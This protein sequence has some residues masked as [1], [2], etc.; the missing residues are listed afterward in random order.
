MLFAGW[1]EISAPIAL[2]FILLFVGLPIA[3]ALAFSG[4][5]GL[6]LTLG[7][8]ATL[9]MLE[10][11][12]FRTTASY[13]LTT[14]G[15][16]VLMA[17]FA[18]QSGITQ[19][20]F[21]AA[22]RFVGHMKGGLAIATIMASAA[23][24][25]I[26]GSSVA[27]AAT[28]AG[29]AIPQMRGR[30]YSRELAAGVVG[31]AGTLAIMIPPSLAMIVYGIITETS[32]GRL[33]L[34][35]IV[36]G[37]LTAIGYIITVRIWLMWSPGAAPERGP[38]SSWAE[39]WRESRSAW[40]FVVVVLVVFGC[41]YTG[42]ITATEAGGIGAFVT[43][44]VWVLGSRLMPKEM[45]PLTGRAFGLALDRTLRTTTMIVTLLIGAYLFSYFLTTT[46]LTQGV[47]SAITGLPVNR[48]VLLAAIIVIYLVL[49]L[50]LSQ[51]EI[52]VLTLPLVF[53]IVTRLGFDPIWFG[54]IVVK[55]VEIGLVTPPVGMNVY[56]VAG[57]A[58]Q[59]SAADGFRGVAPFLVME[60]VVL[61]LLVA[62]PELALFIP[63]NAGF[64]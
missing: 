5:I 36:P 59:V 63:E 25:A 30:G 45:A 32:I 33:L 42:V 47:V 35:G 37:I 41:L 46:G 12:P 28:M 44:V 7:P 29:I 52:M 3:F 34:S 26:S 55:T 48:Y 57:A 64:G 38:R 16:F 9:G 10:T 50:F 23:F 6:L 27:A 54:V 56:V 43:L 18:T 14:V 51:L 60:I 49:G 39:R 13:T 22:N 8:P 1:F 20:L 53:P 21:E 4:A 17:E 40:P 31:I 58:P 24:G 11:L 62:F 19:R 15:M 2:F 61:A